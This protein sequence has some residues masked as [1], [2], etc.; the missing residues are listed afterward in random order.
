MSCDDLGAKKPE[1]CTE[2][3]YLND[4]DADQFQWTCISCP[5]GG[6]C[7]ASTTNSTT[8]R[9]K[10]GYWRIPFDQRISKNEMFALCKYPP[11]CPGLP[12]NDFRETY[13]SAMSSNDSFPCSKILGHTNS[14]LCQK[15]LPSYGRIGTSKCTKCSQNEKDTAA[16]KGLATLFVSLSIVAA[17]F[18][19]TV[20][21]FCKMR[22]ISTFFRKRSES[23]LKHTTAHQAAL[24]FE[25]KSHSTL[26]RIL[27]S[28]LQFVSIIMSLNVPWPKI[29]TEI[30]STVTSV[31]SFSSDRQQSQWECLWQGINHFTFFQ[32]VLIT[33]SITPIVLIFFLALWWFCLAKIHKIFRCG[34]KEMNF[35]GKL[36]TSVP[37]E[38]ANTY[39]AKYIPS[40]ADAWI[41]CSILLHF[42][43]LPSLLRLSF[44]VISCTNVVPES[45]I[46]YITIDLEL[47]CWSPNHI[48]T[49][50]GIALPTVLFYG[51]VVPG[52]IILRLSKVGQLRETD[53]SLLFR[54]GMFHNGYRTEKY[55]WEGKLFMPLYF[56]FKRKLRTH[57]I[58]FVTSTRSCCYFSQDF[59]NISCY[60]YPSRCSSIAR[61]P[62]YHSC[63]FTFT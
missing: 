4:T 52:L 42:L 27:L 1:D 62:G 5:I 58:L 55:W 37:K 24:K 45:S 38:K 44:Q 23:H 35:K 63:I 13:P 7:G 6:E 18:F 22:S 54:Y 61:V 9:R 26:K 3:Q 12:N 39:N 11:A 16:M 15:C 17:V 41:M 31:A 47:S 30:L 28:H 21:V 57:F 43:V 51:F 53:P 19:F 2:V 40:S 25:R 60:V 10:F 59:I 34:S 46:S 14:R 20:M 29:L 50:L 49:V 48:T 33:A 8:I 36:C 32:N 56:I